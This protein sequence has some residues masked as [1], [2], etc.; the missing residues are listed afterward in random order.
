M[1][2]NSCS[3][4]ESRWG[5]LGRAHC[6]ACHRTFSS[7][8]LFDRHRSSVGEHGECLNPEEIVHTRT[9]D[10]VMFLRNGIWSGP[11]QSEELKAR[12]WGKAA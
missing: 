8:A 2:E 9:G 11:E 1:A 10:V 7:V 3:G 4:C 6:S 12:L 5:G